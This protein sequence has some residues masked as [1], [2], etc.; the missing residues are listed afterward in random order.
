MY[1]T[2][3]VLLLADVFENFRTTCIE[4]YKLDPAHYYTLPGF[5]W[6]A[7]LLMTGVQLDVF[8]EDQNDMY[9]MTERGIRGGILVIPHR[10]SKA[11]NKYMPDHNPHAPSKYIMYLDA[12]NLYGWAMIQAL[13][14][15]NYKPA[16]AKDF[17]AEK[18]RNMTNDQPIGYEFD[19]DLKYPK[20]LHDYHNDY[21]LAAEK[22]AIQTE[23]LSSH[24]K[25]IMKILETEHKPCEKLVPN[26]KDK[27][28]HY[29]TL[30]FY[31]ELGLKLVR[32][33]KVVSFA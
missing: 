31:L 29:R 18:I 10:Y 16:K 1:L 23:E 5:A 33:N 27:K 30:K 6:D 8:S 14:T 2:T 13:P 3:D 7:C 21:P 9:L 15:G 17:T 19:V 12:N 28:N 4:S 26:L 22:I 11:N 25:R 20:E 24:T 32:I